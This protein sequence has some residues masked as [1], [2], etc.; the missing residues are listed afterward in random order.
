VNDKRVRSPG[1]SV[2]VGSRIHLRELSKSKAIFD[3]AREVLKQYDVPAWLTL[4][5]DTLSGTMVSAPAEESKFE[6]NTLVESFSK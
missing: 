4:D 3:N 2:A 5:R 1:Y 6:V